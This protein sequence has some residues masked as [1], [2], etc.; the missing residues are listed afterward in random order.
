MTEQTKPAEQAPIEELTPSNQALY[1]FLETGIVPDWVIRAGIRH[2]LQTKIKEETSSTAEMALTRR[3][4]FV[5][6][7]K[8]SPIAIEQDAANSQHY[9]VQAGLYQLTLGPRLK[10]S[11]CYFVDDNVDNDLARA[12]EDM[13]RLTCERADIRNGQKILDLGCGW[14][15]MSLWLA[16]NY[17]ES[18][19][20]GLSNSHSQ[21]EFIRGLAKEQGLNNLK[22]ITADISKFESEA[23]FDRIISVEM[24][25]HMKNYQKLLRKLSQWLHEDGKLFV[26]IFTH[27]EFQYHYEDK[28]GSDWLTR[29][30]FSGGTMPSDGL[31]LYFQDD[32]TIEN[33]WRVNGRHYEKT[34]NAWVVNMDKNKNAVM[35][36]LEQTYGKGNQQRWWMYWRMFFLAC[37]ELWGYKDGEEWMVSHYTFSKKSK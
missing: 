26:H 32:L 22:I 35:S 4:R 21:A 29:Y 27:K 13:L 34:A 16:A 28:D 20:T 3:L 5:Q 7:L 36:V 8:D 18:Q 37:A 19:I 1:K 24:F 10:Y 12:E 11:C 23:K 9:E 25:E 31:L 30:F 15:A 6:E 17:P 14:G 33:H 2:M